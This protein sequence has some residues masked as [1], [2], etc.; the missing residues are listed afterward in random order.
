L[1]WLEHESQIGNW[2]CA[3]QLSE[4]AKFRAPQ[5]VS[6]RD[7]V[8]QSLDRQEAGLEVDLFPAKTDRLAHAK[9]VAVHHEQ[10]G[11]VPMTVAARCRSVHQGF[12]LGRR[13]VFPGPGVLVG[14][15]TRRSDFPFYGV[16]C[17]SAAL[18]QFNDLAHKNALYS[19][20]KGHYRES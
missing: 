5:R 14:S 13:Q 17:G 4:R 16:W 19:P 8:L 20:I 7:A 6:R 10:Q 9:T 3:P 11:S 2:L 18:P 15:A 12:H 1:L